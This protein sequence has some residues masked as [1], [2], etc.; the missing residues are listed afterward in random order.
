MNDRAI[1]GVR[2]AIYLTHFFMYDALRLNA[3][4]CSTSG[5]DPFLVTLY[6]L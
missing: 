5:T 3:N 6:E 1:S 4:G 2:S